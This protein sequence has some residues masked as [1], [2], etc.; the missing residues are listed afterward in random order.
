MNPSV[1]KRPT[2]GSGCKQANDSRMS[3]RCKSIND[4]W[5]L[6]QHKIEELLFHQRL[7]LPYE[8]FSP[9]ALLFLGPARTR[10]E[11]FEVVGED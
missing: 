2:R 10:G 5:Y 8:V 3:R 7:I 6:V 11:V 1:L 9:A 4:P